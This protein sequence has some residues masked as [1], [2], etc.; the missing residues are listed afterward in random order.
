MNSLRIKSAFDEMFARLKAWQEREFLYVLLAVFVLGLV[1]VMLFGFSANFLLPM[2]AAVVVTSLFAVIVRRPEL[3]YVPMLMLGIMWG[4]VDL[5][6]TESFPVDP[7]EAVFFS[8]KVVEIIDGEENYFAQ[9]AEFSSEATTFVMRG[10]TNDGWQGKLMIIGAECDVR[11]GDRLN[12]TAIV[13]KF[14]ETENFG[15]LDNDYLLNNG[16]GAVAMAVQSSISFESFA[17]RYSP[18]N[19]GRAIRDNVFDAMEVLPSRQQALLKGIGF[20][21]TGMLT[22]GSKAVLQQTGIMHIFAVSGMHIAYVTM[23]AGAVLEFLR[24]KLHLD[25]RFVVVGTMMIVMCFCLVVGFS[26]SVVRSAIMSMAALLSLL[27]LRQH[28]AAHA[29]ILSAFVML[30]YQPRWLVQPGFILSFLATAGIIFT[31]SY[32]KMLVRNDTLATTFAA[33]FAVMPVLAYFFNTVSLIGFVISP[34]IALGSGVVVILLLLAMV[35]VPLGVGLVPL[36]GAGLLADGLYRVAEMFAHLPVSFTY[37]PRPSVAALI[38]YYL[39]LAVAYM[40]LARCMNDKFNEEELPQS[41]A[42]L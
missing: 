1:P 22:N 40:I 18:I 42:G 8:G 4:G 25:Y 31:L 38:V 26:A 19:L 27:L 41:K 10:R 24:R 35:C 32:W 34:I 17:P 7:E 33:Q 30:L 12:L 23:L 13:R 36:A 21:E 37:T 14:S 6:Q 29:L 3:F 2:F 28:S 9:L 20:G 11:I 15:L 16:I 39:L 5:L